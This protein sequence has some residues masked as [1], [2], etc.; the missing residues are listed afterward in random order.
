MRN[1]FRLVIFAAALLPLSCTKDTIGNQSAGVVSKKMRETNITGGLVKITYNPDGRPAVISCQ[2]GP[3]KYT[4]TYSYSTGKISY[5]LMMDNK[6]AELGAY[7]LVGGKITAYKGTAFDYQELP[8][9]Y[10][11]EAYLYNEKGLLQKHTFN[12]AYSE[13]EYDGGDN[14]TKTSHFN[15]QGQP[16]TTVTYTYTNQ[17]DLFPG[18][19]YY[20]TDGSGFFL[21]AFSK[22]LPA[23]KKVTKVSSGEVTMMG[24]F[25]YVLDADG[26]VIKSK[27]DANT[28][29]DLDGEW[30]NIFH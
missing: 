7:T 5:V 30:V 19:G 29:G 24:H 28:A 22:Y 1:S 18:L 3:N 10:Y 8:V 13:Y 9:A 27:W 26:Y 14:L 2:Q 6:K 25:S 15:S 20:N 23:S 17:E 12:D 16:T 21:P 11:S 4:K